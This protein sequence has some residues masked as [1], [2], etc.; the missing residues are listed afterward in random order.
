[1]RYGYF[2]FQISKIQPFILL[3]YS[4]YIEKYMN[5]RSQEVYMKMQYK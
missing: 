1:M 3:D 5:T 4:F 2:F